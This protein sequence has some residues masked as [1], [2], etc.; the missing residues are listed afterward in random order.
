MTFLEKIAKKYYDENGNLIKDTNK[1]NNVGKGVAIG[2]GG[3]VGA[4]GLGY[5]GYKAWKK[6]GPEGIAKRVNKIKTENTSATPFS[7][8]NK[9]IGANINKNT[10]SEAQGELGNA[11]KGAP[12]IINLNRKG[13]AKLDKKVVPNLIKKKRK[14]TR[15]AKAK[16]GFWG[17]FKQKAQSAMNKTKEVGNKEIRLF[18]SKPKT[19]VENSATGKGLKR[20]TKTLIK[21]MRKGKVNY[22]ITGPGKGGWSKVKDILT[23]DRTFSKGGK[24]VAKETK[25]VAKKV[26]KKGMKT[27]ISIFKNILSHTA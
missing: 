8:T 3:A 18:G 7:T 19:L 22:N 17:K 26:G 21:K 12:N 23:K 11:V 5:G 1:K 9:I 15:R 10:L 4:A 25:G 14:Y 6:W 13:P 24:R 2:A 27:A 16:P 20:G